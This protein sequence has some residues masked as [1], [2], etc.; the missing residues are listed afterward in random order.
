MVVS[1]RVAGR[2]V[3]DTK[4]L[5]ASKACWSCVQGSGVVVSGLVVLLLLGT[6]LDGERMRG[7]VA[8]EAVAV[9]RSAVSY[10][11]P[12]MVSNHDDDDD[13][14]DG[15]TWTTGR[16]VNIQEGRTNRAVF[17]DLDGVVE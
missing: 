14:G 9:I 2:L 3:V 5:T 12:L 8:F 16:V 17:P 7:V 10:M 1:F 4:S 6:I 15:G 11:V 13:G